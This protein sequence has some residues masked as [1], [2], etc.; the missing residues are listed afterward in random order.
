MIKE[1]RAIRF[2]GNGYSDAWKA[3]A[4]A[5]GLDCETSTPLIFDRYLDEATMKM[6]GD[7]GVFTEVEL[8][9]RTEVK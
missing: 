9:A 7:M 8:E 2:D 5:R 6:F 4:A 1:C 3:E